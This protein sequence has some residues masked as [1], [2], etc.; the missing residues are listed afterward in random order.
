MKKNKEIEVKFQLK[1]RE[2]VIEK[3][4]SMNGHLIKKPVFQRTYGFFYADGSNIEK[5][6]F[7]RVR[8]DNPGEKDSSSIFTLKV[9][10]KEDNNYFRRKEYETV[11][12]NYEAIINSLKE[13][14]FVDI[15]IFDKIREEWEIPGCEVEIT[16]DSLPFG[17][18]IEI[19]GE[20]KNIEEAIKRIGIEGERITK[21]YL[22]VYQDWCK[23]NG[24]SIGKD[25][26]F[27]GKGQNDEASH[28]TTKTQ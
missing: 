3:I 12:N 18:F 6:L 26:L 13:L 23:K 28:E 21:A 5:G 7:P 19:E 9:K 25:V 20:E 14:G 27:S 11:V 2:K 17:D 8:V 24:K 22:G 10:E 15:R 1:K 4:K 16:I